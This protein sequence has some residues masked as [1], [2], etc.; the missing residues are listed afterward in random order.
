MAT[1]V[2]VHGGGHGG[3]CYQKVARLLQARGHIVYAPS[4]GGPGGEDF[5]MGAQLVTQVSAVVA[6]IV[7]AGAPKAE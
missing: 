1:F 7:V 4:L 2:L 6:T 3:W 5:A